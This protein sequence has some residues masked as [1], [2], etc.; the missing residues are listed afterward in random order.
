MSHNNKN[1]IKRLFE[2]NFQLSNLSKIDFFEYSFI[3]II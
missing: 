3:V 2:M 1:I